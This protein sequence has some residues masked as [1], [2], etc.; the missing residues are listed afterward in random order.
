MVP[1]AQL[2]EHRSVAARVTGANPV[3]HPN[4]VTKSNCR[5]LLKRLYLAYATL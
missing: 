2:V 4:S 1:I 5:K 3:Q